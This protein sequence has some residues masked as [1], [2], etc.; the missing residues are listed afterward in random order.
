MYKASMM[1]ACVCDSLCRR[2]VAVIVSQ[3]YTIIIIRTHISHRSV[4][5]KI[6]LWYFGI[7]Y[8]MCVYNIYIYIIRHT[9]NYT[10]IIY[11]YDT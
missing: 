8:T 3:M 6:T 7:I 1:C 10:Y 9:Y 11:T 4:T 2:P 5:V